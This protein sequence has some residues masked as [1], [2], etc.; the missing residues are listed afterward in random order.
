MS[1][2]S[3]A[4]VTC[5]TY[6]VMNTKLRK[7]EFNRNCKIK[8]CP[9]VSRQ[10]MCFNIKYYKHEFKKNV[11]IRN[12]RINLFLPVQAE[13][14]CFDKLICQKYLQCPVKLIN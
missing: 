10:I 13:K 8:L 11:V 7:V 2:K 9:L 12:C 3:L 1:F 4:M 6:N 5:L 14:T